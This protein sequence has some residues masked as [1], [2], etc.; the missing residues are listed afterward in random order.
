MTPSDVS[1]KEAFSKHCG[2]RRKCWQPAFSHF[3]TMFSTLSNTEIIIYVTF[4]LLSANASNMDKVKFL[5]SGN[6]LKASAQ[7]QLHMSQLT[8][9]L[10]QCRKKKQYFF[11]PFFQKN[12]ILSLFGKQSILVLAGLFQIRHHYTANMVTL[13]QK[14]LIA[15]KNKETQQRLLANTLY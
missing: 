8:V 15:M 5:S 2:K 6:G 9:C 3:P 12:V 13:L 7:N 4:I 14:M 11:K 10:K 1:G